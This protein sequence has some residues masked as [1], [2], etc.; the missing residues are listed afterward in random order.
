MALFRNL[1]VNLQDRLCGVPTYASAQSLDFLDL[2]KNSSFLIQPHCCGIRKVKDHPEGKRYWTAVWLHVRERDMEA[3]SQCD[4]L[5][6]YDRGF[7]F[8]FSSSF[9]YDCCL[10]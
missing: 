6:I 10:V 8:A 5:G 9:W 3:S 7:G 1:G 2:A 4:R